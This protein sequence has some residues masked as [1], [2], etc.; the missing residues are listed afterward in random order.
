[1]KRKLFILGAIAV[2]LLCLL[3]CKD[4]YE[5]AMAGAWQDSNGLVGVSFRE[6]GTCE[7]VFA[8]EF[9]T[10]TV[11]CVYLYHDGRVVIYNPA[12]HTEDEFDM[13]GSSVGLGEK[14][15]TFTIDRGEKDGVVDRFWLSS[16]KMERCE[17]LSVRSLSEYGDSLA[18]DGVSLNDIAEAYTGI[19]FANSVI[20]WIK[21][22]LVS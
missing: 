22:V 3:G 10:G 7:V 21:D 12:L 11:P 19:T 1:M 14:G 5:G 4:P 9:I 16:L 13:E 17:T 8:R 20:D 6:D 18:A 2:F 15:L